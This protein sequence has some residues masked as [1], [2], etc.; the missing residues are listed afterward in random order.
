MRLWGVILLLLVMV[1]CKTVTTLTERDTTLPD[2]SI[3]SE[4]QVEVSSP[5]GITEP[6][7]VSLK[8]DGAVEVSGG[9]TQG[10][11][12]VSEGFVGN[13]R[14]LSLALAVIGAVMVFYGAQ[15]PWMSQWTGFGIIGIGAGTLLLPSLFTMLTTYLPWVLLGGVSLYLIDLFYNDRMVKL[16]EKRARPLG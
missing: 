5:L 9:A 2:G 4:R 14:I 15:V 1:G 6:A 8:G 3:V 10:K 7:R 11:D 13:V 12:P 16:G